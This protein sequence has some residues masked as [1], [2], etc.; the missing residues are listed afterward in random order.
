MRTAVKRVMQEPLGRAALFLDALEP[1]P[2]EA[3]TVGT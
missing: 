2:P 1:H 3:D